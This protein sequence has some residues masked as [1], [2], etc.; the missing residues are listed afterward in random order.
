M[1]ASEKLALISASEILVIGGEST[2]TYLPNQRNSLQES[3]NICPYTH[4]RVQPSLLRR[5]LLLAIDRDH[6]KKPQTVKM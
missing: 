3:T 2:I 1:P 5:K 6:Y 4:R